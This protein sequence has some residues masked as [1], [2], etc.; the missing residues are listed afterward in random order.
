M[1][2]WGFYLLHQVSFWALIASA[3]RSAARSRP[4]NSNSLRS[5]NYL[6]LGLNGFFVVLRLV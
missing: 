1:T 2:A 5:T 4:R 3:L 6:A